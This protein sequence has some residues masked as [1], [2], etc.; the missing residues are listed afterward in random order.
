MSGTDAQQPR[1]ERSGD[2]ASGTVVLELA[3][4]LDLAVAGRLHELVDEAAVEAPRLVV[5]DVTEVA[6]MDSSVLRE[7]LRAHRSVS[8]A[9]GLLVVAGAQPTVRRLLELTGT[10]ELFTLADTRAAALESGPSPT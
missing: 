1:L 7:F 2:A 6:F 3:G 4:E 5:I 9:G 10:T 8:E